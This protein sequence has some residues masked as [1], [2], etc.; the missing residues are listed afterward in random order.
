MTSSRLTVYQPAGV[1]LER[2]D[3][4]FLARVYTPDGTLLVEADTTVATCLNV[5]V[6]L[7]SGAA[8][9]TAVYSASAQDGTNEIFDTLQT[10]GYWTLDST[11]YNFRYRLLYATYGLLG[12]ASYRVEFRITTTSF[13]TIPLAYELYVKPMVSV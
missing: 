7:T 5:S 4:Y 10:D 11:G 6:F 8:P 1:V 9:V 3:V 2:E 12:G 13:G